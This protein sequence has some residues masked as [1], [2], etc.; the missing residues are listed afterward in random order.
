MSASAL[1]KCALGAPIERFAASARRF[2][3]IAARTVN[4]DAGKTR[5]LLTK[6]PQRWPES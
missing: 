6:R 1:L 3:P 5:L 2:R 4:L